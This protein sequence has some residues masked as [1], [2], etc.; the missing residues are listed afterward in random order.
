MTRYDGGLAAGLIMV[1]LFWMGL[2]LQRSEGNSAQVFIDNRLVDTIDLSQD[3]TFTYP[4]QLGE[5]TVQISGGQAQ[6]IK[7]NCPLK[8]CQKLGRISRQGEIIVCLPNKFMVVMV[9]GAPS[10]VQGVSG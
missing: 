8:T 1:S 9:S 10:S 7:S 6:V 4:V 5:I 3:R 2:R